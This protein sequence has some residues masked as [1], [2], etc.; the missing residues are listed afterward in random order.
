M[1]GWRSLRS[2][3]L[4]LGAGCFE[5][6]GR[7]LPTASLGPSPRSPG[8][9]G[10]RRACGPYRGRV[11]SPLSIVK[12]VAW[13]GLNVL[14][15]LVVS[16]TSVAAEELENP[17]TGAIDVRMGQRFFLSKCTSCHGV[18][19]K[20]GVEA[21]GP[22]LTT[23]S[24]RH[25]TTDAGLFR[26]IRDGI[27]GTSMRGLRREKEQVIWQLVT[28]LRTLSTNVDLTSLPGSPETGRQV[29]GRL[30]CGRCHKV[31]G[32]GG[33]LGPDL[34][35]VGERRG[36]DELVE[37]LS[38]PSAEVAP[39][40]WTV[41]VTRADGTVVE[42]LRMGEDTFNLRIMDGEERLRSFAKAGLRSVERILESTMP[43]EPLSDDERDDLVAYLASL[44]GSES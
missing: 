29:F 16:T 19:A 3:A 4:R 7:R 30:D 10:R 35:R 36:P 33:R 6:V 23:G 9:A 11:R 32:R 14:L 25:A 18:D 37:D 31:D 13:G 22:D 24:F 20:G 28:Y 39:R 34:S 38:A 1:R 40:W 42:G 5:V 12:A 8:P 21:D 41:R 15:L 44:R 43:A 17:F 26:V 27:E 2:A